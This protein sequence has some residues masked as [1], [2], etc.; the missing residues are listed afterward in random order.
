[1]DDISFNAIHFSIKALIQPFIYS[2][3]LVECELIGTSMTKRYLCILSIFQSIN[4]LLLFFNSLLLS[5][6]LTL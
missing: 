5:R 4:F 3:I 1:M 2:Q 6:H